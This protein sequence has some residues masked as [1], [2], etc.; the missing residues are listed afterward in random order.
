[1][2]KRSTDEKKYINDR[3]GRIRWRGKYS[4]PRRQDIL[5]WSRERWC[6]PQGSLLPISLG[7]GRPYK[8][9]TYYESDQHTI[10]NDTLA[11]KEALNV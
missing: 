10:S 3:G 2:E 4:A 9:P 1:M 7:R 6:P 5:H 8:L 11:R